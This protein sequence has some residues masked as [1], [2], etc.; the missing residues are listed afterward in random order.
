ETFVSS[1]DKLEKV[2]GE[3]VSMDKNFMVFFEKSGE[4]KSRE[5][6][7][8]GQSV[9]CDL[10]LRLALIDNMYKDAIPFIVLD[11]PFAT[12]DEKHIGNA[13]SLL[14]LLSGDRQIIYFTCHESRN[15]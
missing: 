12:L 4:N 10:C 11:D 15:I 13:L 9:L 8:A 7:S 14:K 1:A 3:K 6:L 5:Y 2:L